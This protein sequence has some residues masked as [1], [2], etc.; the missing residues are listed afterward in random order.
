[1]QIPLLFFFLVALRDTDRVSLVLGG[2]NTLLIAL[3][4]LFDNRVEETLQ[5][6][7]IDSIRKM[8]AKSSSCEQ[9]WFKTKLQLT[10]IPS[11]PPA[12]VKAGDMVAMA[13]MVAT[14]NFMFSDVM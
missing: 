8:V 4:G 9:I 6:R 1:M 5:R 2:F 12:W 10:P 14:E 7:R 13:A 3:I 11:S